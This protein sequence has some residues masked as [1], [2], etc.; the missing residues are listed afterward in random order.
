MHSPLLVHAL[1]GPLIHSWM[2]H[3]QSSLTAQQ[4]LE[5]RVSFCTRTARRVASLV[6]PCIHHL[7]VAPHACVFPVIHAG[8]YYPHGTLKA[9]LCV[10]GRGLMYTYCQEHGIP[11]SRIGKLIVATSATWICAT[12]TDT[13][14][15][16]T[17]HAHCMAFAQLV[18]AMNF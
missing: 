8:M 11:H 5:E 12:G 6:V 3:P 7:P 1:P 9:R 14:P 15:K 10:E 16:C 2:F 4:D 13:A 18:N 17:L